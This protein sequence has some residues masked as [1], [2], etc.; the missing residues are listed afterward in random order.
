MDEAGK[1]GGRGVGATASGEERKGEVPECQLAE[2]WVRKPTPTDSKWAWTRSPLSH[3][4]SRGCLLLRLDWGSPEASAPRSCGFVSRPPGAKPPCERKSG[5]P[6]DL[7]GGG[8]GGEGREG[9]AAEVSEIR[10]RPDSP[11]ALSPRF[12][13]LTAGSTDPGAC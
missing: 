1:E 3:L 9:P 13:L 12:L 11:S 8:P 10:S 7:W 4:S 2:G 6:A 5:R